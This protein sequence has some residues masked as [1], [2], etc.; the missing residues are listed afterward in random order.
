MDAELPVSDRLDLE[1]AYDGFSKRRARRALKPLEREIVGR[2]LFDVLHEAAGT[3]H[4]PHSLDNLSFQC[5]MHGIRLDEDELAIIR[6]V[7][8]VIDP[9][10]EL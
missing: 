5:G 8:H 6:N 4:H 3:R 10:G 7:M 1:V 9:R 2:I